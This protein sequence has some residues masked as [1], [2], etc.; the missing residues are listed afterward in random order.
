MVEQ[1]H[2]AGATLT[3]Q[4]LYSLLGGLG[5]VI[6]LGTAAMYY[7]GW[8][9]SDIQAQAMEMDVSLF[10]FSSQ[11]YVLRGLTSLYAPMLVLGVLVVAWVGVHRLV[12]TA[13][14]SPALIAAQR[15]R[16]I[17]ILRWVT[18]AAAALAVAYVLFTW[19]GTAAR[20][21]WPVLQIGR[22]ISDWRWTVPALLVVATLVGTYASWVRR[23]L[24]GDRD[25]PP[26][27]STV[28]TT[29]VVIG[30]VALGLFWVLEDYAGTIG[31]RNAE[32]IARSVPGL[33][34]ASVI[35]P[36]PLH[37]DAEGVREEP[38]RGGFYRTTGLR[39][40]ARSDNKMVVLHN[41]WSPATGTVIVLADSDELV[42]QFR[43]SR[44]ATGGGS[45]C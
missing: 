2:P 22:A 40:L 44:S 20:P 37:I 3:R 27:W 17:V 11:D 10:G 43:G 38:V 6:T 31:R 35:S 4:D 32:L 39:L 16:L 15:A 33:P 9:R 13:L 42:W 19:E 21:R 25:R 8:R 29:V 23:R 36:T 18:I 24:T 7:F 45:G 1:P 12:V 5:A 28:V 26:T 30:T 41:D 34:C 14:A